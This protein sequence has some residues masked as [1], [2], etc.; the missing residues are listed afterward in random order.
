MTIQAILFDL[1]GTLLDYDMVRDFIPTYLKELAAYVHDLVPPKKL[2]ASIL[3]TSEV[4]VR[5]TGEQTNE[6]AFA[7]TFYPM[8]GVE[9][10]VL[11]PRFQRFYAEVFPTLR[12]LAPPRP[13]A[14]RVIQTAFDLGYDVVIAT[15]PHFPAVAVQERLAWADV[16]DFPYRKVTTYENS[17]FVKPRLEYYTEILA[18]IDCPPER[19]V[20]VGDDAMDMVAGE[21][22]CVTYL[23]RSPATPA[24][25]IEPP[26]TFEGT[27]AALEPLLR[28]WAQ[29]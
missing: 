5:G 19:A 3:Q 17:H 11:E 23:V 15:N 6:E 26:P 10:A 29:A 16:A 27:L 18:D 7:A 2:P 20:M 21:L 12:D 13:E 28:Q 1:D 8:V 22:G 25:G 14:R 24:D 4:L 9:R